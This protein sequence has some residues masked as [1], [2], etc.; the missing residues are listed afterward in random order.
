MNKIEKMEENDLLKSVIETL[1]KLNIFTD[2]RFIF[3]EKEVPTIFDAF[4]EYESLFKGNDVKIYFI[5][6]FKC[7][8]FSIYHN[9]YEFGFYSFFVEDKI[10]NKVYSLVFEIVK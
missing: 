1:R 3:N 4:E 9:I 6:I 10:N 7:D 8:S 2:H 5:D